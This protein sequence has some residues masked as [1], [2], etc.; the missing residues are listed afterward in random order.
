MT[1]QKISDFS[2]NLRFSFGVTDLILGIMIVF[3]A[4]GTLW[5]WKEDKPKSERFYF[6]FGVW[7]HWL[8]T[9]NSRVIDL[10]RE[11]GSILIRHAHLMTTINL[12]LVFIAGIFYTRA[13]SQHAWPNYWKWS[14]AILIS[15]AFASFSVSM[16]MDM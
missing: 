6:I 11:S 1:P 14:L 7:F 4:F 8:A 9:I 13:L 3:M 5:L 12:V 16:Y 2:A 10:L 15:F